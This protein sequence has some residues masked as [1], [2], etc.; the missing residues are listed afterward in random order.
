MTV[1]V[2]RVGLSRGAM[3]IREI[4]WLGTLLI[5]T[6]GVI[7]AAT[8]NA[9]QPQQPALSAKAGKPSHKK[10]TTLA[11][12]AIEPKAI[13]ILKAACDRL[14]AAHSMEFTAI[15]M[16]ENLSLIGPPLAYLTK[17][18]VAMQRPDKLRVITL[19]DGPRS[20]FCY[21][22]QTMMA[23][24]PAEDLVAIAPAPPTIDGALKAAYES[25]AIYY[26]F[27]DVIVA[28]PYKDLSEGLKI[29][30]YIGQSKV[31]GGI[32]T[33]MVACANDAVFIQIWIGAEDKLPRM[34]RAVF[35]S[36][37]TML[38]HEMVLSDWRIDPF[39]PPDTF[40]LAQ[41]KTAKRIA[42]ARPDPWVPPRFAPPP[43]SKRFKNQ[44]EMDHE[45]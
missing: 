22:G 17:S 9:Q 41:A 31:I 6:L 43:K 44:K 2:S 19:A 20:D 18:Q 34:L 28:D 11:K 40:T 13:A 14:A 36:D 42:F 10:H 21:N 16:Y 24:A 35:K 4:R 7:L 29:A 12:P 8:V 23:F 38:R 45:T 33:D 30:F 39:I 26:P 37:P 5:A 3:S 25:A 1:R 15:V 32:T 27:S